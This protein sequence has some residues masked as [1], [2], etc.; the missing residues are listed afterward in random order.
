M[1]GEHTAAGARRWL[2][3]VLVVPL[4]AGCTPYAAP[5]DKSSMPWWT[6]EPTP[7]L[8]LPVPVVPSPDQPPPEPPMLP[9]PPTSGPLIMDTSKVTQY[10][11]LKVDRMT[12][13]SWTVQIRDMLKGR[14]MY[15]VQCRGKGEIMLS[16]HPTV[17]NDFGTSGS[18]AGSRSV[19]MVSFDTPAPP[20]G[21]MDV[22]VTAPRG[23]QW[24]LLVTQP[25]RI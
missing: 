14:G 13:T 7:T 22:T 8:P 4:L 1:S 24:A 16:L 15:T 5:P 17:G 2:I 11:V 10:V 20:D 21:T 23:A 12:Q 3:L 19:S 9:P 18:C 6:A 25:T